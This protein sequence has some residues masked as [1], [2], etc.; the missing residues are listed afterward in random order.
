LEGATPAQW[1]E[2]FLTG[3]RDQRMNELER[4][5][6]EIFKTISCH[7]LFIPALKLAHLQDLSLASPSQ[8]T[9]GNCS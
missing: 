7:T 3:H 2:E 4:G 8:L 9:P 5:I 1:L 6:N